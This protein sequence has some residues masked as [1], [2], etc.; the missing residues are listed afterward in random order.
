MWLIVVLDNGTFGSITL[1][2]KLLVLWG[3]VYQL[4]WNDTKKTTLKGAAFQP[5]SQSSQLA[6]IAAKVGARAVN[7]LPL[8]YSGLL[9]SVPITQSSLFFFFI[10]SS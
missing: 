2:S 7:R 8:G 6:N 4:V 3:S 5:G 9:R 10:T 1:L